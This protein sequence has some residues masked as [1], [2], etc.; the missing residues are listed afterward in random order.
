MLVKMLFPAGVGILIFGAQVLDEHTTIPLFTTIA[1]VVSL[2]GST[3]VGARQLQK[4]IDRIEG[5]EKRSPGPPYDDSALKADVNGLRSSVASMQT[6]FSELRMELRKLSNERAEDID[7]LRSQQLRSSLMEPLADLSGIRILVVDDNVNDTE[8]LR[9]KL[10]PRFI[11]EAAHSLHEANRK[12]SMSEYDLIILDLNLPDTHNSKATVSEFLAD[13][14][15]F[16]C[17]VL[18]GSENESVRQ[19]A[20]EQG[21]DD[22]WIKGR[23]DRDVRLIA[24]RI[25]EAVWRSR[26]RT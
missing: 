8:L 1:V 17:I 10:S 26:K 23:D 24:R 7:H 4:L 18:T 22:V 13:N 3:F 12:I 2:I 5:L 19:M 16:L 11:V 9:R 6:E 20:Y 21:A 25:Q 15:G 14:P